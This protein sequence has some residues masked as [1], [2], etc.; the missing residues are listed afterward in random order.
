MLLTSAIVLLLAND[1]YSVSGKIHTYVF[2]GSAAVTE[3]GY[4]IRILFEVD[5]VDEAT[6]KEALRK[7]GTKLPIKSKIVSRE[8]FENI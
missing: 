7:A 3:G 5:G 2:G 8:S 6:A 1:I 4:A